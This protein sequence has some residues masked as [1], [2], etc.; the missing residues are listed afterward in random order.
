MIKIENGKNLIL[1]ND[2][3]FN[4]NLFLNMFLF[5]TLCF[6][7][8]YFL[9][10]NNNFEEEVKN[11]EQKVNN[12]QN[13]DININDLALDLDQE[14]LQNILIPIVEKKLES[15]MKDYQNDLNS[16][17]EKNKIL[18]PDEYNLKKSITSEL[19]KYNDESNSLDPNSSNISN[20]DFIFDP[21]AKF[22]PKDKKN[23]VPFEDI[24]GMNEEKKALEEFLNYLEHP[25]NYDPD[26]IGA[27]E[28]PRGVI[29]YGCPG[30]GKTLLS[31]SLSKKAGPQVSF[32]ELSSPEFSCGI[33]GEGPEKVRDL[34]RD[35]RNNNKRP[36]IKASI[37]FLDECEEI[38]K[39]LSQL[40]ENVSK[41]LANIVNQ[42]KTETTSA[43][44]DPKKPILIIGATNHY[45]KLDE[46][47]K[48][49]FDYH[50][51]V[52][53]FDKNARLEFL[54]QR[55]QKRNNKYN[56][57]AKNYLFNTVNEL[58]ES[59]PVEKRANR[60]LENFLNSIVRNAAK[61]NRSIVEKADIEIAYK[62][63]FS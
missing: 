38:F 54:K 14:Q 34:F 18:S 61:N 35:V 26:V 17:F 44:N 48:S 53:V 29:L 57:E 10:I 43:D 8:F 6:F 55:I 49:R 56:D 36:E 59:F 37:I 27:I 39:N 9:Y 15:Q 52:T 60:T 40:G 63:I 23:F 5:L 47:I 4:I 13:N 1:D 31:R 62:Q 7:S 12:I 2:S 45:D 46:A 11:L 25:E 19:N 33:Y 58:I 30:T 50:I 21:N 42:F 3:D 24:I 28:A 20:N 32:Y 41:D 51:E 22:F 16:L